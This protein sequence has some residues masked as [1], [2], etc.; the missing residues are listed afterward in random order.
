[1]LLDEKGAAA[2]LGCSVGLMR[3]WRLFDS[4]PAFCKLGRLVRYRQEDL[5]AFER[6]R[7]RGG[8]YACR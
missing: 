4:G 1:M 2:Y 3:K 5:V 7:P 8:R 6:S